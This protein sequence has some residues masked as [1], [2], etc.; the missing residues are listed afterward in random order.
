MYSMKKLIFI[1][2]LI[3]VSACQSNKE[4]LQQ[5]P[6]RVSK[7]IPKVSLSVWYQLDLREKLNSP[8][9]RHGF[10]LPR[11]LIDGLRTGQLQAYADEALSK[12]LYTEG[13]N[14]WFGERLERIDIRSLYTIQLKRDILYDPQRLMWERSFANVL[15]LY[16][17]DK[18]RLEHSVIAL[19][20]PKKH[21]NKTPIYFSFYEVG[22]N[23][24][25][26]H[27]RSI[28]YNPYNPV[29]VMNF[30][31]AL[32]FRLYNGKI[33]KYQHP[34]KNYYVP[35]KGEKDIEDLKKIYSYLPHFTK[36]LIYY[37]TFHWKNAHIA[38]LNSKV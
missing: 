29:Q 17:E 36:G 26:A 16:E 31:D 24:M 10:E 7:V 5:S 27:P 23:M 30:F 19:F 18:P 14:R 38:Y 25:A 15:S 9:F 3:S 8:Y 12:P 37:E 32:Q 34:E 13:V 4:V 35:V 22:K 11:L 20:P 33:T 28:Y 21:S 2:L 1:T 6:Y